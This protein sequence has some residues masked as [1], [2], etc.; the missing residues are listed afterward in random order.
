MESRRAF[1]SRWAA[2]N[3][4]HAGQPEIFGSAPILWKTIGDE[5]LFVKVISDHRQLAITLKCWIATVNHLKA[6]VKARDPRLDIK[7]TA[8]TAGFPVKNKE[9]VISADASITEESDNYFVDSGRLLDKYYADPP[10]GSRIEID[11]IGPSIDIGFRISGQSTSRKFVISVDVAYILALTNPRQDDLIEEFNVRYDGPVP[12]KGVFGGVSYPIFWLDLSLPGALSHLEDKLTGAA[13]C[14]RDDVRRYCDSFYMEY[15]NY[16]HRPFVKAETE[17]HIGEMP[18]WYAD[19]HD[20]MVANYVAETQ[21]SNEPDEA[22]AQ[23]TSES[24]V[25]IEK[26]LTGVMEELAKSAPVEDGAKDAGGGENQP[27]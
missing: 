20:N 23:V 16:T 4:K 24:A 5:V 11:Y 26:V 14:H 22:T 3:E 21:P 19:I 15:S 18:S 9:V 2:L 13:P 17:Q 8:W 27:P 10:G 25:E 12:L 1:L 7:A 6:F